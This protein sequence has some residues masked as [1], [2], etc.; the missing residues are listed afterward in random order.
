MK[1]PF[2]KSRTQTFDAS[3]WKRN[4]AKNSPYKK[5]ARPE[6][7]NDMLLMHGPEAVRTVWPWES[8]CDPHISADVKKEEYNRCLRGL[9]NR[10]YLAE[11]P[12]DLKRQKAR[13][14]DSRWTH[15]KRCNLCEADNVMKDRAGVY[16]CQ[17]SYYGRRC[18]GTFEVTQRDA[19]RVQHMPFETRIPY[20]SL[21]DRYD[22]DALR[23]K[24]M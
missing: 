4:V 12:S 5:G 19:V 11:G 22:H 3:A 10:T 20:N 16:Q 17:N 9:E 1:L 13:Y 24:N 2:F 6:G 23:A 21:T 8:H 18:A 14:G 7:F 15:M